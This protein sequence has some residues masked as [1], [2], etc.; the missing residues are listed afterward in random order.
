MAAFDASL[1][2]GP[3]VSSLDGGAA[4]WLASG[5][6]TTYTPTQYVLSCF[7]A[8][9]VQRVWTDFEVSTTN[10]PTAGVTL[11]YNTSTLEVTSVIG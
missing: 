4:I 9:G 3:V 6:L 7:D 5:S 10:A 2:G 11:P 1:P 8:A